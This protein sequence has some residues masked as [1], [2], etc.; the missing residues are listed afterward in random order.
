M[1]FLHQF[2]GT[3]Q[4]LKKLYRITVLVLN[5]GLLSRLAVRS[6][7]SDRWSRSQSASKIDRSIVE[8]IT[9]KIDRLIVH[10][11][12]KIKIKIHA[13]IILF[14][15]IASCIFLLCF[16]HWVIG[17]YFWKKLRWYKHNIRWFILNSRNGV[18]VDRRDSISLFTL[19][20]TKE[21]VSHAISHS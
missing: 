19:T 18:S 10:S 2:L 1:R 7:K 4:P 21:N 12:R 11:I 8:L 3:D 20:L 17:T 15:T 6:A 14:S 5:Y 16:S 9:K 13:L